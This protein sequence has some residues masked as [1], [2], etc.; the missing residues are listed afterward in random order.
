MQDIEELVK[1]HILCDN[2]GSPE[3]SKLRFLVPSV[4]RFFTP[5]SLVKAFEIQ[6]EKRAISSRRF[7]APSFNDIRVSPLLP[8]GV[9]MARTHP[10]FLLELSVVV[11]AVHSRDTMDGGMK[12]DHRNRSL[13]HL[14]NPQH[15][16]NHLPR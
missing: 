7:V 13:T 4:G 12:I 1:D 15:R 11:S 16:S 5:L 14:V 2:A 9:C 3:R 6:D 8:S 10:G